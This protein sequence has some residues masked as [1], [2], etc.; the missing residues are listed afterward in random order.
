MGNIIKMTNEDIKTLSDNDL[1][2]ME[3][4]TLSDCCCSLGGNIEPFH[5]HDKLSKEVVIRGI[6]TLPRLFSV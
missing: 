6:E 4:D 2:V 3:H 5:L 1:L